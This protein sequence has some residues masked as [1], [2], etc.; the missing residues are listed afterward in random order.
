MTSAT[1]TV[2]MSPQELENAIAAVNNSIDNGW[3]IFGGVLVFLM[4][5]GFALLESGTIRQKNLLNIL[6]KNIFCLSIGGIGWYLLGYGLAFGKD[7]GSGFVGTDHFAVTHS[8][9][10]TKDG[11]FLYAFWYFQFTFCATAATIVSGA[12]AE[13][14]TLL[15]FCIFTT[16]L[17]NLIYPI[18]VHWTWGGG[19]LAE[20][21]YADFAGSGV[22]HMVGGIAGLVGAIALGP[23]VGRFP[24]KDAT[25]NYVYGSDRADEFNPSNL[26]YVAIGTLILWF[27]WFGFNAGSTVAISGLNAEIAGHCATTTTLGGAVGGLVSFVLYKVKSGKFD[28]AAFLNG[29]LAGLVSITAGTN[30][31]DTHS[32][33]FVGAVGACILFSVDFLFNSLGMKSNIKIDDPLNAFAVHGACGA[34]GVLAVGLFDLDGGVVYGNAAD[35]ILIP[36]LTG[37]V[38]IAAWVGAVSSVIWFS[39]RAAKIIRVDEETEREGIDAKEFALQREETMMYLFR[40]SKLENGNAGKPVEVANEDTPAVVVVDEKKEKP[41]AVGHDNSKDNSIRT[42]ATKAPTP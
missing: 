15:A 12:V 27:G 34:W 13:R 5:A 20:M 38:A 23:R 14:C 36:N 9:L 4:H 28:V 16:V 41:P 10:K 3:T 30:N 40:T 7:D 24:T 18:V 22:V 6:Q 17:T 2:T 29:T 39:M 1:E 8:D 37:I 33:V 25:G 32:A 11:S 26:A 42:E 19:W 21:G 31:L 35:K